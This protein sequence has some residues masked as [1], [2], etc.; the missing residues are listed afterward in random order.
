MGAIGD[1]NFDLSRG[2]PQLLRPRVDLWEVPGIDGYGAQ[3][4]G[5]GQGEF[6]FVV[7]SYQPSNSFANSFIDVLNALQGTVVSLTD[8]W[9]DDYDNVLVQNVDSRN[10]KRPCIHN[11]SAAVRVE[12]TLRL[13][14]TVA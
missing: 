6:D 2:L 8:D 9:G 11:G 7:V 10:A 5:N 14:M 3:V 4:L 12:C 13:L 1:V